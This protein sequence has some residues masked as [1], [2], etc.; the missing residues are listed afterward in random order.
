MVRDMTI[1]HKIT[2]DPIFVLKN[3]YEMSSGDICLSFGVILKKLIFYV[4]LTKHVSDHH[5]IEECNK[6]V[7]KFSYKHSK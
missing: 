1:K 6:D 2:L 5:R 3:Q 7:L 4:I